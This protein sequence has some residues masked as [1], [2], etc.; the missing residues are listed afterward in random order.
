MNIFFCCLEIHVK[1]VIL[2]TS[3][4]LSKSWIRIHACTPKSQF[5]KMLSNER[6][7]N[8]AFYLE[9]VPLAAN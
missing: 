9:A 7:L 4:K 5:A 3:Q 2:G 8:A 6:K 1:G